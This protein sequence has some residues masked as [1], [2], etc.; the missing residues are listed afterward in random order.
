M[1]PEA[2]FVF[3]GT[4]RA[5]GAATLAM[6]EPTDSTAIVTVDRALRIADDMLGIVGRDITVRLKKPAAVG[7]TAVFAAN[8][9]LYGEGVAVVEVSRSPL[10]AAAA[11]VTPEMDRQARWSGRLQDRA[12][13]ADLV[14]V[15]R[16]TAL[17]PAGL[18]GDDKE[19]GADWWAATVEVDEVIK[20]RRPRQLRVLF[21]NSQDVLWYRA[22]V[23]SAGQKAVLLLHRG[24][25]SV[26]DKRAYAVLDELDVQPADGAAAVAELL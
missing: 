11:A 16:V 5:V 4:V 14:V 26:P 20:G 6:V 1:D 15:G 24:E 18:G 17:E 23:L 2:S 13:S 25:E 9:W 7:D 10:T 8:G 22:P 3:E 21:S 12:A 19:H